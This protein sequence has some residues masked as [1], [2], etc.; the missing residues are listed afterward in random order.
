[1]T[2]SEMAV[3]QQIQTRIGEM[4]TIARPVATC[5][6]SSS[7]GPEHILPVCPASEFRLPHPFLQNELLGPARQSSDRPEAWIPSQQGP[8]RLHPCLRL[9]VELR[10]RR[11]P[12]AQ[13]PQGHR[14]VC[15]CLSTAYLR[16]K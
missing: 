10:R 15:T 12:Q 14:C 3:Y 6:K 9:D 2:M 16:C 8:P 5:Y 13:L 11:W 4:P 1:M 7:S